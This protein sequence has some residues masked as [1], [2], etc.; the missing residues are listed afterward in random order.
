MKSKPSSHRTGPPPDTFIPFWEKLPDDFSKE[1]V[2]G[3]VGKL[4]LVSLA[5]K[6]LS[7]AS[8]APPE[9]SPRYANLGLDLLLAA[10]EED[11][12]DGHLAS[13]LLTLQSKLPGVPPELTPV[14][15]LVA[16]SWRQPEQNAYYARILQRRETDKVRHFLE[17]MLKKDRQNLYWW[18]Q[19]FASGCFDQDWQWLEHCL[20]RYWP[21]S[22]H[23]LNAVLRADLDRLRELPQDR[24]NLRVKMELTLSAAAGERLLGDLALARGERD[25]AVAHWLSSIRMRPWQTSLVL[26]AHDLITGR[27]QHRAVL[28]GKTLILLYSY[29]K[30]DELAV[31]LASLAQSELHGA[32]IIVLDNASTDRT[33]DVLRAWTEKLGPDRLQTVGLPVNIGAPAARN[34]L[35]QLPAAKNADWL[36][37]LDDDV[38]LPGDW[39]S[40]LGAARDL[41]PHAGV[42]GCKVVDYQ[43]P[44]NVQSADLHVLPCGRKQEGENGNWTTFKLSNL[45]HQVLDHPRFSYL[46]PCASVT[47]CCHLFARN[48]LLENGGFDLRFSPSQFDDLDHDLRL[49]LAGRTAV[50]QGHLMVRHLKQT[51]RATMHNTQQYGNA[52]AN[53]YKLHQKYSPAMVDRVTADDHEAAADDLR[54]KAQAVVRAAH[55]ATETSAHAEP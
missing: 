20:T 24:N 13:Q 39:I 22:L 4:H 38:S 5:E 49:V 47:G 14:L 43:N 12:L 19:T 35:M 36:V 48:I 1:F 50:Y 54:I 25:K 55:H 6:A 18:Q 51:G 42:W 27:D 8:Q 40:L 11:L 44:M 41:Y 15:Q 26:K 34:W 17:Q 3:S 33:A 2:L 9:R 46:R 21:D 28:P 45:H 29:N 7:R 10:W 52:M 16:Q 37:Y 53:E 23:P 31:T 32:G 30:A